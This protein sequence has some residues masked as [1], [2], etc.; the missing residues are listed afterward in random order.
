VKK[1]LLATF[2]LVVLS[3]GTTFAQT[4]KDFVATW[5]IDEMKVELAPELA[6]MLTDEQKEA[7][8]S[9]LAEES[10]KKRGQLTFIFGKDGK[11]KMIDKEKKETKGGKWRYADK[12][13]FI[14]NDKNEEKPMPVAIEN[15]KMV[16]SYKD[17][18]DS[19]PMSKQMTIKM[20]FK[21]QK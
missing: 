13:I 14:T 5:V 7:M 21:K 9:G 8:N 15:G 20:Y 16:I 10:A 3:L 19:D 1:L 18:T 6:A 2:A 17:D 11:A 4:Q 12:Q